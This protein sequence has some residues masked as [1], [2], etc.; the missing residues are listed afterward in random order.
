M[1]NLCKK[2]QPLWGQWYV[3]K[4]LGFGSYGR[5]WRIYCKEGNNIKY[6][7]MKEVVIPPSS[8]VL[9]D[10]KV[11]GLNEENA[12]IYFEDVLEKSLNEVNIMKSLMDCKTIVRFDEYMVK[13]ITDLDDFGWVIFIRM[14]LLQPFKNLI[15]DNMLKLSDVIKLG[16]DICLALEKCQELG[17]MHRD[18]KPDNL[19]YDANNNCFKLGD[20]GIARSLKRATADKGRAGTLSHM[21]PQVYTGEAFT[22]R[23]DLYALGIILYRL[24]NHN[25]LPLL[26]KYPKQ[27]TVDQRDKALIRRLTGEKPDLP[28][29]VFQNYYDD[30][31]IT[32]DMGKDLQKTIEKV[33]IIVQ[34][35]I[36]PNPIDRYK[37]AKELRYELEEVYN[38]YNK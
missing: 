5:V 10:A 23:D 19:F 31:G 24:L 33:G 14:E 16:I 20:F 32:I 7:A 21:S 28:D 37:S 34:K 36:L 6:A 4:E 35:S 38:K 17:I 22:F 1:C 29:I 9:K 25:R 30:I 2:Y 26:P 18:I 12:K 3:D 15:L 11:E 27:F 13:K 8:K